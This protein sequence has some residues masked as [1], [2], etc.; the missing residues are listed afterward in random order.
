MKYKLKPC[1]FC[2]NEAEISIRFGAIPA[3]YVQCKICKASTGY[4]AY[5]ISDG[6]LAKKWNTRVIT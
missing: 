6:E 2:G 5:V 1:P 4:Y 3:K